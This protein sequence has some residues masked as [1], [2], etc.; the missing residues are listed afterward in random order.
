[1]KINCI[2]LLTAVMDSLYA[3]CVIVQRTPFTQ[4]LVLQPCYKEFYQS[5]QES[6]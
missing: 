2:I 1:M 4:P 5:E 3:L 6:S